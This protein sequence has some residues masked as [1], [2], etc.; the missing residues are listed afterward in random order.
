MTENNQLSERELEIL[1]LVATGASNKD[2]ARE[3]VI[4]VNTVKVHLKNIYNKL[5]V[6]SRTEATIYA[7]Q[8]GI[9]PSPRESQPETEIS[10]GQEQARESIKLNRWLL[11]GVAIVLLIIIV[12]TA[13]WGISVASPTWRSVIVA[14]PLPIA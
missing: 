14:F 4:S 10:D 1:Q 12:V 9:V 3:L 2:I 6:S 8:N 13:T 7:V 5:E 11:A